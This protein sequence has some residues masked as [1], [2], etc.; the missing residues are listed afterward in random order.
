MAS[1]YYDV[2]L[3]HC[4]VRPTET[5]IRGPVVSQRTSIEGGFVDYSG[6]TNRGTEYPGTPLLIRGRQS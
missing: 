3:D 5:D 4:D 2:R 1:N 6:E